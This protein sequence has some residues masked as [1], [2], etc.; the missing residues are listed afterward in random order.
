MYI[1]QTITL[2]ALQLSAYVCQISCSDITDFL[3][4][5]KLD[6]IVWFSNSLCNGSY[7]WQ[8]SCL[9]GGGGRRGISSFSFLLRTKISIG[10]DNA[11]VIIIS[12][13]RQQ[14]KREVSRI[15]N[16]RMIIPVESKSGMLHCCMCTDKQSCLYETIFVYYLTNY[17]S[18]TKKILKSKPVISLSPTTA[19][20][21]AFYFLLP[22]RHKCVQ[23]LNRPI[24]QLYFCMLTER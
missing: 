2:T 13:I 23:F 3:F 7:Y 4:C 9:G 14:L 12:R 19:I 15:D 21:K 8:V 5:P 17:S 16:T 1:K 11:T 22:F 24:W 6:K 20:L 10:S 18:F